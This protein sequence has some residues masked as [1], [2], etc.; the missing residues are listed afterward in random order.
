ME[1]YVSTWRFSGGGA[2]VYLH[3]LSR[4]NSKRRRAASCLA[5]EIDQRWPLRLEQS[6]NQIRTLSRREQR[7]ENRQRWPI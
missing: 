3:A 5:K 1:Q 6:H 2:T 4:W 7:Q